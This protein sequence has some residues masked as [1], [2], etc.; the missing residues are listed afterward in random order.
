MRST[1][2][3]RIGRLLPPTFDRSVSYLLT[4]RGRVPPRR[5]PREGESLDLGARFRA[6]GHSG[7]VSSPPAS[8][9]VHVLVPTLRATRIDSWFG[10]A[11][12][13]AVSSVC[14]GERYN[15]RLFS[16]RVFR[17]NCSTWA[18]NRRPRQ[19]C[20]SK[21]PAASAPGAAARRVKANSSGRRRRHAAASSS[22]AGMQ[23]A[24]ASA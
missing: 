11:A 3:A 21:S 18:S 16:Q 15:E 7:A 23:C 9:L 8:S 20:G 22:S 5:A 19:F 24:N 2:I 17:R 1:E 14:V 6:G 4:G 13:C 10:A 12:S